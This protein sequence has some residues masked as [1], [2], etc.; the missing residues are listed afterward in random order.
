VKNLLFFFIFLFGTNALARTDFDVC[1]DCSLKSIGQAVANAKAGQTIRVAPGLY[2]ERDI[3]IDKPLM[4]VG[5]PNFGS[6]VDADSKGHHFLVRADDVTIRGF[7]LRQP[8]FAA[9][10]DVASIRV[11]SFHRC[12]IA[13]NR[14]TDATYGIY[15]A[16]SDGCTVLGNTLQTNRKGAVESGSGVHVWQANGV[17]IVKNMIQG[18][19]DGIYFEFV[20]GSQALENECTRNLRYGLH[21]MFSHENDYQRNVFSGNQSG[22][23]V[24][25]SRKITMKANRFERSYGAASYGLL[26]KDITESI[27]SGNLIGDNTTGLFVEG[28]VRT[29][30]QEND[31]VKNGWAIRLISSSDNNK[32]L[33]NNFVDN[34]FEVAAV[35]GSVSNIFSGNYWSHYR[36]IDLDRNGIGDTPHRPSR[37]S[38]TWVQTIDGASLLLQ[39]FFLQLVDQAELIL[40]ALSTVQVVDERPLVRRRP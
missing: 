30:I 8:G 15:L 26:L 28:V 9:V 29:L 36:G 40:P 17:K 2:H 7:D 32:F 11:D 3:L 39:S 16:N 35:P 37:L 4:L 10:K 24:M 38:G 25:Y 21:F 34:T 20:S 22:V 1:A 6:V 13:D 19:R 33:A 12:L 5:A 18:H 27:I 23:A 14:I 31:I